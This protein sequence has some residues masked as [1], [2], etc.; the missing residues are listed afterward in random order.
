MVDELQVFLVAPDD[1]NFVLM[2]QVIDAITD[3]LHLV[4]PGPYAGKLIFDYLQDIVLIVDE[5]IHQG[6]IVCL[7]PKKVYDRLRMKDSL[8]CS[9]SGSPTQKPKAQGSQPA[10]QGGTFSSLFGFAK[11]TFNRSLNLG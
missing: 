10:Q 9:D 4:T 5:I 8:Q 1:E 3:V 6:Y 11:N 2:E 7:E